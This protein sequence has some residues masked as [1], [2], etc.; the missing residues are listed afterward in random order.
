MV[1][2]DGGLTLNTQLS[3]RQ[4]SRSARHAR[5]IGPH[6]WPSTLTLTTHVHAA[7]QSMQVQYSICN[8]HKLTSLPSCNTD[9]VLQGA[10][11]AQAGQGYGALR[12]AAVTAHPHERELSGGGPGVDGVWT[13]CEW[14]GVGLV[15]L[16]CGTGSCMVHAC[17]CCPAHFAISSLLVCLNASQQCFTLVWHVPSLV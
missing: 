16:C 11:A 3:V 10:V 13:A 12:R 7:K 1:R 15:R 14:G 2:A 4:C 5:L 6:T 8:Q 17:S 9:C